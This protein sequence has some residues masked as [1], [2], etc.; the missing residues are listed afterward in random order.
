MLTRSAKGVYVSRRDSDGTVHATS[1]PAFPVKA[2][3]TTAA[4]DVFN[5]SLAV[6]IAAGQ[7]L[8]EAIEVAQA[9][10]ALSVQTLGAQTSAPTREMVEQFLQQP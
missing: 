10:A 1:Y 9:A 6:G 8:E 3:D 5:G 4:G 2:L 7:P